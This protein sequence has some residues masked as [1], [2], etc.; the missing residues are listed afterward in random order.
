MFVIISDI[1][2][3]G[4]SIENG[5]KLSGR[6]LTRAQCALIAATLPNPRRFSSKKPSKYILQRQ[7]AILK[8]MKNIWKVEY[9]K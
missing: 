1:S 6:K 8:N 3:V 9:D 2:Y 4:C 5:L 7:K